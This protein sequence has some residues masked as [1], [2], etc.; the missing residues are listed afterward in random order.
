VTFLPCVRVF[1]KDSAAF[2][3]GA[4]FWRY[5]LFVGRCLHPRALLGHSP[6]AIAGRGSQRHFGG[7]MGKQTH[8]EDIRPDAKAKIRNVLLQHIPIVTKR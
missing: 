8:L 5:Y 1:N 4:P 6:R 2:G 3:T 7:S